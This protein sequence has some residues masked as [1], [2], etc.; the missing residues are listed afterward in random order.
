MTAIPLES[1][2]CNL[3]GADDPRRRFAAL[4][5]WPETGSGQFAATADKFGAYG[6]IVEC[7]RCGLVFTNPRVKARE[8]LEEYGSTRDEEYL[9]ER[10]SRSMN[11]YL[12]MAAI[13]RCSRGGRLLDVGCSTG[14]FLNAA[15]L[16]FEVS[17]VEPSRWARQIA[18]E[19]LGLDVSAA[20]LEE[21]RFPDS[22]FD[23]VTII[24]VIEHV[25]DPAGL[26]R[27]VNRVSKPGGIV[28]LV[29]PYIDSLSAKLLRGRWW[30][31][32]PAHLYYF[33]RRTLSRLLEQSGY[34]IVSA[35]SYGR[36]F[37]WG[38][39]LSRLS[40]YPRPFCRCVKAMIGALSLEDKFLY[41]DTRDTVQIVA[42]KLR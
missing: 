32:R 40:N 8:V 25:C 17:G 21:A 41:L 36:I 39:W 1:V 4:N 29:T 30:G 7:R 13:R 15:R 28:Y 18:R 6:T 27:E 19:Q 35:R 38:Y 42:R 9:S 31:L 10:E 37:T 23:V 5:G 14:Y 34:E 33:S 22:R 24:D 16:S 12:A 11:A 26:L 2:R 3:C 20:T